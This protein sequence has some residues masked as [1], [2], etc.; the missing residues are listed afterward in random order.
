MIS[1]FV[2]CAIDFIM[3]TEQPEGKGRYVDF[4]PL[5]A[6]A[7]NEDGSPRLNRYS[8]TITSGHDFP[9]AQVGDVNGN[10]NVQD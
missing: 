8:A 9:A 1:A 10:I 2:Y 6:D 5:P 3:A 7:K 4:P